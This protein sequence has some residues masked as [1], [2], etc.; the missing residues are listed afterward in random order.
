[1]NTNMITKTMEDGMNA[2]QKQVL[3]S[4]AAGW[5]NPNGG[6]APSAKGDRLSWESAVRGGLADKSKAQVDQ[7]SSRIERLQV[8]LRQ[9]QARALTFPGEEMVALERRR[10]LDVLVPELERWS[11]F[12]KACAPWLG[13]GGK[14]LDRAVAAADAAVVQ[15]EAPVA[16][17]ESACQVIAR[18]AAVAGVEAKGAVDA[19]VAGLASALGTKLSAARGAATLA[20]QERDDNAAAIARLEHEL[21]SLGRSAA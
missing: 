21:A 2:R 11:A 15:A 5:A 4:P 20:R 3:E 19:A 8:L 13:H 12:L 1:M 18:L 9:A 17:F 6:G 7:L 16:E 14:S 10:S